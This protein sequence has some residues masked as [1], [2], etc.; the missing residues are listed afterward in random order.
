MINSFSEVEDFDEEGIDDIIVNYF[1]NA[2][3]S[4]FK[5]KIDQNNVPFLS[6]FNCFPSDEDV[7]FIKEANLSMVLDY[8][9]PLL[10]NFIKQDES[11]ENVTSDVKIVIDILSDMSRKNVP[12][13]ISAGML[14]YLIKH[15][16]N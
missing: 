12:K 16:Y 1:S 14:Y 15:C 13:E 5:D 11:F 7:K 9:Y 4:Y 6:K 2:I 10:S 3:R 8:C